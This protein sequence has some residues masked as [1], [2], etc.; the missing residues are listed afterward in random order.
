MLGEIERNYR[1]NPVIVLGVQFDIRTGNL[2]N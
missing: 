1:R 2:Q